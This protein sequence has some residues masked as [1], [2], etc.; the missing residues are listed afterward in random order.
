M[1]PKLPE[2]AFSSF[3]MSFVHF[4]FCA[5]L[6]FFSEYL[7]YFIPKISKLLIF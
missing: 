3:F 6:R 2:L 5:L 4:L 1:R 7:I